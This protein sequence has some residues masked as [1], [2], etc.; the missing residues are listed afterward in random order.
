M[1]KLYSRS[2]RTASSSHRFATRVLAAEHNG[3]GTVQIGSSDAITSVLVSVVDAIDSMEETIA[4]EKT[5]LGQAAGFN[6]PSAVSGVLPV[7]VSP[8]TGPIPGLL[9]DFEAA[10]TNRSL[11]LLQLDDLAEA[12]RRLRSAALFQ[13]LDPAGSDNGSLGAGLVDSIRIDNSMVQQIFDRKAGAERTLLGS[14]S[15]TLGASGLIADH[16]QLAVQASQLAQNQVDRLLLDFRS[17][18]QFTLSDLVTALQNR[19]QAAIG[20]VNAQYAFLILKAKMDFL[21][22]SGPYAT[23]L[24]E[25]LPSN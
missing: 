8:V 13:W 9:A 19:T 20:Q 25:P 18:L 17:G 11:A 16:Y 6:D 2:S 3:S 23:L 21:T 12:A 5:A 14:V 4:E 7:E 15:D 22:Y 10:A 24:A 1:K